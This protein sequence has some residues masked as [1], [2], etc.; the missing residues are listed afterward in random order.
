MRLHATLPGRP[1]GWHL[2]IN[3]QSDGS[4][5]WTRFSGP[6][7]QYAIRS[8][9]SC[10][11]A[12]RSSC[13]SPLWLRRAGREACLAASIEHGSSSPSPG[14]ANSI[15]APLAQGKDAHV[16]LDDTT[17]Q[18]DGFRLADIHCLVDSSPVKQGLG[19]FC[20]AW[21]PVAESRQIACGEGLNG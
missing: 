12:R 10:G 8:T 16:K 18:G 9:F 20:V 3:P 15:T 2:R 14:L 5:G 17:G 6:Y 4:P 13:M 11:Y 1:R 19:C 7:Y 21:R